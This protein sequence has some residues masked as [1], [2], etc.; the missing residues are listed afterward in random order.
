MWYSYSIVFYFLLRLNKCPMVYATFYPFIELFPHFFIIMPY[1]FHIFT[2]GAVNFGMKMLYSL[3]GI[4]W[5]DGNS[6]ISFF[7][8]S[9]TI[10]S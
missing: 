2:N 1:Y 4:A 3:N 6:M 10:F 5:S 9:H 8:L 7:K